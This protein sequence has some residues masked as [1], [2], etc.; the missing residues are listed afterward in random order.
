MRKS[1]R[2]VER[3]DKMRQTLILIM[4]SLWACLPA[5]SDVPGENPVAESLA[6]VIRDYEEFIRR[7][8][9]EERARSESR[10]PDQWPDVRASAL[11]ANGA[12]AAALLQRL[13]AADVSGDEISA[14]ILH[15]LLEG[16][17]ERGEAESYAIPFTGDWGFQSV[18]S[19]AISRA[20]IEDIADAEALISRINDI[21]DFFAANT[22]N[23]RE[24]MAMNFTAYGDPLET[25]MAQVRTQI[26]D[27]P[28]RSGL[29]EPFRTLPGSISAEEQQRLQHAAVSAIARAVAASAE[30]LRFLELEY[31]P[32][33]RTEAGIGSL[34]GG[35]AWYRRQLAR[36]TTRPDLTPEQVHQTGLAE[37]ARIRTEME[38][39]IAETGFEG[40]FADFLD[41]LRSDAQFYARTPQ[42][43][44]EKAST[45]SKR[46]DAELPRFF[47]KLPRLT[48]GVVPVPPAIAPGYTTGRYA[49]GDPERGRSGTY[50]V[51][52]YRLDQRP[53]YQLPALTAHEAVPGHHLQI[54]LAQEM[55]DM[56]RFR[57]DYYATA[58]GE[59]W[60]LYA[61]RLAGEAGLYETPYERF[62][63]LSYEM[64]RACR[65]V[66]DTGLHWYGWSREE[67]E[68][69]F[70]Q[71]TALAPHNIETEVTRYIG[72]PGQATAYKIGELTISELRTE[73]EE[74]LGERFDIR[75]FHD[76]VLAEGSVPLAVLEARVRDWIRQEMMTAP[77]VMDRNQPSGRELQE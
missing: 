17:I 53:L 47:G 15:N 2:H 29:Y 72:W 39:I 28:E 42:A 19:F 59:G 43:L 63:A 6:S 18:P 13:A 55:T 40:S 16:V 5:Y 11:Q 46:L 32:H 8:D 26:V 73:A 22:E 23:M 54:A 27:D 69:C 56:P 20:R 14:R 12:E 37:V 9:P 75:A 51:N 58:F 30:L 24:G 10:T 52:T 65:L 35:K 7:T 74:A 61:E 36:H 57:R 1:T 38:A 25:V 70:A 41:F 66:A 4:L 34:P 33:A 77:E 62:G 44:I 49:P 64:W 68:A 21:P 60:G 31:A 67:A 76:V 3:P 71:N 48:Y 45:L 50:L